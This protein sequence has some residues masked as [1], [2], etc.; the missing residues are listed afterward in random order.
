MDKRGLA[1]AK[2]RPYSAK[3]QSL[4][5]AIAKHSSAFLPAEAVR[6]SIQWVFNFEVYS[7]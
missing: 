1:S 3:I 7:H 5:L 6:D 4:N 2:E